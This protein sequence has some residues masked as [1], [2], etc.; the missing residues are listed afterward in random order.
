[1]AGYEASIERLGETHAALAADLASVVTLQR[2]LGWMQE[3]GLDLT[4]IDLI[5]Q[6][7]FCY[8]MLVPWR[9]ADEWLDFGMG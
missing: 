5:Q 2:L 3:H 6:D 1:M 4:R 9:D 8:D 7:E